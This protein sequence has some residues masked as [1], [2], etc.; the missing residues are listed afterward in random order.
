MATLWEEMATHKVI[1]D[2]STEWTIYIGTTP[3]PRPWFEGKDSWYTN[4]NQT[5]DPIRRIRK[6]VEDDSWITEMFYPNGDRSW[7]YS[8]DDR[9]TYTYL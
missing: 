5:A 7:K 8:R 9:A 4:E 2:T 3:Y 6:F 1:I